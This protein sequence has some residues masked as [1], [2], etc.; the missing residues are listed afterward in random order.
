MTSPHHQLLMYVSLQGSEPTTLYVHVL[1]RGVYD[2]V[3]T[4][5]KIKEKTTILKNKNKINNKLSPTP[6]PHPFSGGL[7]ASLVAS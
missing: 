4:L 6:H 7:S 1:T 3:R 5:P 2:S